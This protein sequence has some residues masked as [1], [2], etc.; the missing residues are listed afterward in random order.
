[1]GFGVVAPIDRYRRSADLPSKLAVFPLSGA[2]LLPRALLPL[3]VF[4]PRYLALVDDTMSKSRVFGVVQPAQA[5]EGA[6]GP[7]RDAA[8]LRRIGCAGRIT[9]YHELDDGRRVVT[10][11]GVARF[12]IMAEERSGKPYR[13]VEASYDRF[14]GDLSSGLGEERVDRGTLLRVLRTYLEANQLTADWNSI[15]RAPNEFLVNALCVMSPFGPEEK[16]ALLEARDLKTRADALIALAQM[17]LAQG[18][19]PAATLQ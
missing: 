1:M 8:P 18:D 15:D 12:E 11:T 10:L 7:V 4:E 16:Q 14:S 5:G 3:N 17:E 2:I 6:E 9:L 19:G 13:V